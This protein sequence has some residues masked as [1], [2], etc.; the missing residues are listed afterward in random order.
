MLIIQLF[1]RWLK[2]TNFKFV[3]L[4]P[5]Y[6]LQSSASRLQWILCNGHNSLIY[7]LPFIFYF[8]V[9]E[10]GATFIRKVAVTPRIW[11]FLQSRPLLVKKETSQKKQYKLFILQPKRHI[12]AKP[13]M[14]VSAASF[15]YAHA[16]EMEALCTLRSI[17]FE[18]IVMYINCCQNE[19]CALC[20][21]TGPFLAS[22]VETHASAKIAAMQQVEASEIVLWGRAYSTSYRF[23]TGPHL[24]GKWRK[25]W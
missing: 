18:R 21:V 15:L 7:I 16:F 3:G 6:R 8:F 23:V 1:L 22:E 9:L 14:S 13:L 11:R 10:N 20:G 4:A 2:H 25:I 5:F 17:H 24:A 19:L 12:S